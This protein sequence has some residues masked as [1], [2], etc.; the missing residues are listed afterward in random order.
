MQRAAKSHNL[1]AL[2]A[3]VD[4]WSEIHSLCQYGTLVDKRYFIPHINC[5]W[6]VDLPLLHP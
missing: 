5:F 1:F 6:Y 3:R 4:S 2:L